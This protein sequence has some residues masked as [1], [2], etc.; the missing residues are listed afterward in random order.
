MNDKDIESL[1]F[2]I[3]KATMIIISYIQAQVQQ[4]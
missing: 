3:F 1:C 4:E 2:Q